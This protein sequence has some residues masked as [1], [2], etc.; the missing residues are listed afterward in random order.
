MGSIRGTY[1]S[2][3]GGRSHP[4]S[5][6][7]NRASGRSP[8]AATFLLPLA[9][10]VGGFVRCHCRLA[11]R[12][13]R[14][15]KMAK[16]R[17]GYP[18]I[19][20][21]SMMV[22]A[23]V[24]AVDGA[25]SWL[26]AHSQPGTLPFSTNSQPELPTLARLCTQTNRAAWLSLSGFCHILL[27]YGTGQTDLPI[28]QSG[29]AVLQAMTDEDVATQMFGRSP[30][31]R[32]RH[33]LRYY[34]S[35]DPLG[36]NS[37]GE[38]HRDQCLATFASLDVPVTRPIVLRS[39]ICTISD[40]LSESVA[41]FSF[42]QHE[43]AWTAMA[44]AHY[45][46]PEKTWLNR[47]GDRVSFSQLAQFLLVRDYNRESCAGTHVLQALAM[48]DRADRRNSILD[49]DTRKQLDSY[50]RNIVQEAIERQAPDGSWGLTWCHLIENHETAPLT[51]FA[52]RVLV[53]GHLCEV[54]R[55]LE[56]QRRP[57]R[58]V[59]ERAAAW[60]AHSLTSDQIGSAGAWLCPFTHAARA[61]REIFQL[62][63]PLLG[64]HGQSFPPSMEPGGFLPKL[65]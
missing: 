62:Y 12:R 30:F 50:L 20:L 40:L 41:N 48:L 26:G 63:P 24:F 8:A 32:T 49:A 65:K 55:S 38:A 56:P 27:F 35:R 3:C 59:F 25:S 6:V 2:A 33:G 58:K 4:C 22:L 7:W 61:T 11:A 51:L 60:L 52:S 29:N 43:M 1:I 44:Y 31:V 42:D 18:R 46:P 17:K 14:S 57:P 53:T 37:F 64:R 34:L 28:F 21:P 13:N 10:T 36:L 54:L 9:R 19:M 39:G 5:R 47:F 16:E 15:W 23:A 45:L